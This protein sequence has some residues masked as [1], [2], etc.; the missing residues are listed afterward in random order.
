MTTTALPVTAGAVLHIPATVAAL[1]ESGEGVV[2]ALVSAY[3]VEYRIGFF[4]R[5]IIRAGAFAASIKAQE[6]IPLFWQHDWQAG[7][8]PVGDATATEGPDGLTIKGQLYMEDPSV[9][10]LWRAMKAGAIREWS[11]GYKVLTAKFSDDDEDL[12]EVVE[13]ELLEASSVLRGANPQTHTLE[14]ASRVDL[15]DLAGALREMGI[16]PEA[17]AAQFAAVDDA[18][19]DRLAELH[20]REERVAKLLQRAATRALLAP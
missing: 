20:A 13:G 7:G 9:A 5:H 11:I 15:G 17:L 8:L 16:D 18:E 4:A 2:E 1:P 10:R 3:D 14:V 12:A 19:A 6:S